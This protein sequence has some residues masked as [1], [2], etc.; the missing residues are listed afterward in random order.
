MAIKCFYILLSLVTILEKISAKLV[1]INWKHDHRLL[2]ISLVKR[3]HS[4]LEPQFLD[5]L[6][7]KKTIP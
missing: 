1:K 2:A 5:G 7:E 3:V 4:S 6:K